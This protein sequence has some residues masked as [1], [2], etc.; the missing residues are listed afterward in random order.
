MEPKQLETAFLE[1]VSRVRP[2]P[3]NAGAPARKAK[4]GNAVHLDAT[5]VGD[6]GRTGLCGM[7]VVQTESDVSR[8]T[9]KMCLKRW[10]A[11][12][13]EPANENAKHSA[14]QE[15]RTLSAAKLVEAVVAAFRSIFAAKAPSPP[16]LDGPAWG[17]TCKGGEQR[18]CS[19]S[20]RCSICE[21]EEQAK[22]AHGISPWDDRRS[23]PKKGEGWKSL[24]A[25]LEDYKNYI[26]HDR[27]QPSAQGGISARLASGAVGEQQNTRDMDRVMKW[28]MRVHP[29][30]VALRAAFV[31]GGSKLTPGQSVAAL[32]ACTGSCPAR[33]DG[34]AP[35][36]DE[37]YEEQARVHGIF[38]GE[39]RAVVKHGRDEVEEYLLSRK[40]IQRH[41]RKRDRPAGSSLHVGEGFEE[42]LAAS[43]G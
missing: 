7:I 21:W 28:Y 26:A 4:K 9:C 5:K 3:A 37:R 10:R 23:E 33:K 31:D 16:R 40:L 43:A 6:V 18:K 15:R 34:T 38:V 29:V 35:T 12:A 14:K 22:V 8:V 2:I 25:A 24:V 27:S 41:V 19:N 11:Q 32:L 30:E 36:M 42:G 1:Q 13:Q 39:L 20:S 17:N